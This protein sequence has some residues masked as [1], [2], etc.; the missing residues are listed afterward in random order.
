MNTI[1]PARH[2]VARR[3][4][5]DPAH[6]SSDD[7]LL[8]GTLIGVTS[9]T[10]T[11]VGQLRT[12]YFDT[13]D[14][15]LAA[16]GVR[17]RRQSGG[18]DAGWHLTRS[19][20]ANGAAEEH[21][22]PGRATRTPP[23]TL[24]D[25]VLALSRGAP[26]VQVA[27][28]HTRRRAV[29]LLD[30]A[31]VALA[32]ITDD[33]VRG[34]LLTV[35]SDGCPDAHEQ[36]REIGVAVPAGTSDLVAA[37]DERLTAHGAV[38]ASDALRIEHL[39][40]ATGPPVTWPPLGPLR[41]KGSAADV[42]TAYVRTQVEAIVTQDARVRRD[43]PDSVHKMRVATRRL[44]ST[45][46]TFRP[47]LDRSRTDPVAVELKWVAEVLGRMRDRE[48]LLA[49]LRSE[50][51]ALSPED[52][53]GPVPARVESTLTADTAAARR[54]ALR[55]LGSRRYLALLDAL[56]SLAAVP[57]CGEGA[58]GRADDVLP[59]LVRKIH[60]KVA[61]ALDDA[62]THP[63]GEARDERLHEARKLAKRLRYAGEAL[64]PAFGRDAARLASRA[65]DLQ[66]VLGAHQDSVVARGELRQL[67][68]AAELADESAYTYGLL[69]AREQQRADAAEAAVPAA[70]N[71]LD[72]RKVHRLYRR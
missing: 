43:E 61:A 66:E 15:R 17:L 69:V 51:D 22:P 33:D 32:T 35:G 37:I 16:R 50:L 1:R 9:L 18:H 52:V 24:R 34:E 42:V 6:G 46:R 8:R 26:L 57:P 60:R 68:G 30:G 19:P 5:L 56:D 62:A 55:D 2:D 53:V 44:R 71:R 70:R 64:T 11:R 65:E 39:L 23:K 21:L 59:R 29:D 72:A 36:W 12:T 20:T 47:L 63:P 10:A 31:G 4:T 25:L 13:A 27:K 41:R 48:V 40:A 58:T 67:G 49:R 38:S 45:L 14:R 54:N 7:A 28:L 3:Y